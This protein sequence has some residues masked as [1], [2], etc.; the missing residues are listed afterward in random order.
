MAKK[1]R[2]LSV[3]EF[4]KR[5]LFITIGAVLM[6][7]ALELFLVP[8][9]VLDGGITGISIMVTKLTGLPLGLFIFV[10]NIPFLLLGYKQIGKTFAIST[11]YGISVMSVTTLLL[12]H[13]A[14]FTDEKVLAVL[15]GGLILGFGVGLVIRY[16]GSLDGT[17]IVAILLSKRFRVPVGQIIMMINVVIFIV[18]GFIFGWDS[19]MYS[20]FTFYIA[21]KVM[22]IVVEGLEESKSATIIS[23]EYEEV[24]DAIVNRLGRSTTFIYARG[25]YSKE[26]TQMIYCVVT[27]LE[28]A[29]LKAIVQEIDPKAFISIQHVSDVLGGNMEKKNIH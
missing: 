22:D 14:A 7:T 25:G 20:I 24:S 27:R 10:F 19:A 1:H 2:K 17:E 15:F 3:V 4:I 28:V 13:S 9:T 23:A 16:G 26:D 11:L 8:N 5:F 12:H 6:A 21:S 18:A 29:K